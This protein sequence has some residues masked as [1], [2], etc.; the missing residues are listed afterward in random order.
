M[1]KVLTRVFYLLHSYLGLAKTKMHLL[2]LLNNSTSS[3]RGRSGG[4][5]APNGGGGRRTRSVDR[6]G[7]EKCSDFKLGNCR[8]GN[9]CKFSHIRDEDDFAAVMMMLV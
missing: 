9:G 5:G 2:V 8:R 6:F 4:R 1:R 7:K 3:K